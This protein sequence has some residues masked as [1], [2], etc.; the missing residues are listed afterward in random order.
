MEEVSSLI[1]TSLFDFFPDHVALRNGVLMERG[2][3]KQGPRLPQVCQS[4][5]YCTK[6]LTLT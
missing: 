6:D 5:A 1:S 2:G 4:N 3:L